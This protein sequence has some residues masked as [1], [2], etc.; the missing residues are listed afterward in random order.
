MNKLIYSYKARIILALAVG[1]G[2][3]FVLLILEEV[4]RLRASM[5]ANHLL[6]SAVVSAI[7]FF[8]LD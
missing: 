6:T 4:F 5:L 7:F 2:I 3:Y 1:M 8:I